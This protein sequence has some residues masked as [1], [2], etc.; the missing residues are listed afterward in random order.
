MSV[1]STIWTGLGQFAIGVLAGVSTDLMFNHRTEGAQVAEFVEVAGQVAV[2]AVVVD[3]LSNLVIDKMDPGQSTSVLFYLGYFGSQPMLRAKMDKMI[4][5]SKLAV[6][7][8]VDPV[9]SNLQKALA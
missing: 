8:L 7:G 3:R 2:G 4:G 5:Q 6:L 1:I 9:A